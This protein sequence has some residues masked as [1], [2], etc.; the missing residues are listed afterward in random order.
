[1]DSAKYSQTPQSKEAFRPVPP[2][3]SDVLVPPGISLSCLFCSALYMY[4][5]LPPSSDNEYAES[6]DT[7]AASS[8]RNLKEL[9]FDGEV[10]E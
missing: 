9:G 4:P 1:M 5:H 10:S 2:T 7:G 3:P 8:P 6:R